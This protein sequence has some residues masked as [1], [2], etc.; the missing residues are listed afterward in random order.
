MNVNSVPVGFVILPLS[1]ENVSIYVPELSIS[2]SFVKS[3]VT[4]VFGA[5][6]PD[7][8]TKSVLQVTKPLTCI[9]CSIFE[10]YFRSFLKLRLINIIHVHADIVGELLSFHAFNEQASVS[11]A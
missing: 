1:L 4:L 9:D 10:L 6:L 2:T 8:H 5:I 7:L 11:V 3:P